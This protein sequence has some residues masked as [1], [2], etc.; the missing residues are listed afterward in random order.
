MNNNI[1]KEK[2]RS[3][4]NVVGLFQN[5][6]NPNITEIMGLLGFDFVIVDGEHTTFN[7]NLAEEHFRA[8]ELRNISSVTRIGQN[9]QQVIQKFLDAGSQG[10]LMPLI[11]NKSDA[12]EVVDSVKY[13]PIGKRGLASGRGS[14]YGIPQSV[15]E[16][17]DH[18]NKE[19]LVAIQ[20]E[21]TEAMENVE[22]ISSIEE[23]DVLFFGPS[24]ISSSFGIHGQIND[25]KVRDTISSL[26]KIAIGNGKSCGTIARDAND[27]EFY[28]EAGFQW[29]CSGVT[30][31]MQTGMKE[32]LSELK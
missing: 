9:D 29:F 27:F 2:L 5:V 20:I 4:K 25:P 3:G 16:H 10:V 21:T 32:Y 31:M 13:P 28:K 15:K 1:M 23:V 26:S 24:D 6:I 19:T 17:V 22:E 14:S 12:L 18:S 8:A 11:N 7:P 30:N